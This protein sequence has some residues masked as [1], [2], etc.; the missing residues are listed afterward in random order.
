ME[1]KGAVFMSIRTA[2]QADI[3][4][5]LAIYQP[6]V[7]HT[8]YSFEYQLPTQAEFLARFQAHIA[9][10][11]WLVWEEDGVVLGYAYAGNAFVRAAYNWAAEI[12][13][14][15]HPDCQRRGIGRQLY[16]AIEPILREQGYQVVYA[17]ITTANAG[18]IAFHTALGYAVTATFPRCGYKLGQWHGVVWMEKR[19]NRDEHPAHF[20]VPWSTV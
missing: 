12:S 11:P 16:A 1:A 18:S 17:V 4:A 13:V 9:Q 10:C 5:M 19:L 6:Y 14:Y 2:T 20:P 8:A 15:L 3:P 7:E